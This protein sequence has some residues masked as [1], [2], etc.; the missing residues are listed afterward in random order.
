MQQSAQINIFED[1]KADMLDKL[2]ILY[3]KKKSSAIF[4]ELL[5]IIKKHEISNEKKWVNQNDVILITYADNI[6]QDGEAPL[7]TLHKFLKT[8]VSDFINSA[9][10]L[11]FY[12]Y[13]SDDGFSVIDYYKVNPE[14]GNWN[15]IEKISD[16]FQIMFD[17]VINHISAKSEWF[18]EYLKC[19][20]EYKNFFIEADPT[21]DY[22]GVTRPRALPLLSEFET[23][24]GK[25]H[26]WTTFSADQIDL[27]YKN[28]KV[29]LKIIDLLLTYVD[30][31]ANLLRLDAIGYMWKENNTSCINLP[32]AHKIVQLMRDVLEITAPHVK[33][34]TETNVPH[35]DNISYF[36]NGH[37]EAHMVYNFSLPPLTLH[38]FLTGN[39][40]YLSDWAKS[41]EKEPQSDET[42]FFNF[43]ASHDGI[44]VMPTKGILSDKELNNMIEKVKS[45][46]GLVSY[47]SNKDGIKSVY[48]LNINYLDALSHPDEPQEL[49]LKRILAAHAILLSMRGVPGVYIH[50]LLGSENFHEGVEQT[51]ANRTINREKLHLQKLEEELNNSSSLRYKVFNNLKNLIQIRKQQNAFHPNANQ[52]VLSVNPQVFVLF[53]T[54]QNQQNSI[55]SLVNVSNKIQNVCINLN[56]HIQEN[57]DKIKELISGLEIKVLNKKLELKLEPYQVM[58]LKLRN[59]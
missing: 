26:I 22:S 35:K 19:N 52:K 44:G 7:K 3:G 34:I 54:A 30:H 39:A 23:N 20:P 12:P 38:S 41:L 31:K 46:G 11:P 2:S 29:F 57:P 45:H 53:R 49:K 28:E 36:G 56:E 18:N 25:K 17:A 42:T 13:S 55:I 16:D 8:Y 59:K 48:E 40:K 33:I 37:N 32:Q 10:I 27:N 47:K 4:D 1:K 24:N 14:L 15:D 6:K 51:G 21:K 9:H 50:S 58:W 43:L 5:E